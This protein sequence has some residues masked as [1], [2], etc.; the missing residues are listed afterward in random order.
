MRSAS[1]LCLVAMYVFC[2]LAGSSVGVFAQQFPPA[3]QDQGIQCLMTVNNCAVT[4]TVFIDGD[5]RGAVVSGNSRTDAIT[6]GSH[7]LSAVGGP[8]PI[9][10]SVSV[11]RDHS[12]TWT[13]CSR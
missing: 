1:I 8:Q 11:E 5:Q 9:T 6:E 2:S 7:Q 10:R 4:M 13:L 3:C 12:Y